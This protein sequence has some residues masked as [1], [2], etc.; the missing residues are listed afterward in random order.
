MHLTITKEDKEK[1]FF[2]FTPNVRAFKKDIYDPVQIT[3]KFYTQ[4]LM[5]YIFFVI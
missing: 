5:V 2:S 3:S 1:V 4:G